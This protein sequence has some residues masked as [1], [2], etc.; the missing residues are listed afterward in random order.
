MFDRWS[1]RNIVPPGVMS[2]ERCDF[3]CGG[4]RSLAGRVAGVAFFRTSPV[5]IVFGL[6]QFFHT[7]LTHTEVVYI[8][9]YTVQTTVRAVYAGYAFSSTFLDTLNCNALSKRS[10]CV[11]YSNLYDRYGT[12]P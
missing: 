2:H 9:P 10:D 4:A 1:Q 11:R 12:V 3:R 5:E 8:E 7:T 6:F